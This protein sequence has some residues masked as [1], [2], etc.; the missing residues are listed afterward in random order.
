[1]KNRFIIFV[2]I[3]IIAIGLSFA[4]YS[5][6][7]KKEIS[8]QNLSK[9]NS[10]GRNQVLDNQIDLRINGVTIKAEIADT[11]GLRT[12][13]L[14]GRKSLDAQA[15]L[16]FVFEKSDRHGFWMKDMNFPIDILWM[17]EKFAIV[18][19]VTD[20]KPESFPE[21]FFPKKEARFALELNSGIFRQLDAKIGDIIEI[22]NLP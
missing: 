17:D 4:A 6:Q 5:F 2:A 18:D 20:V 16:L 10:L 13:G 3:I 15:G 12:K 1:M 22:S 11:E 19:A 7:D 14:S 21:T 9:E 8:N